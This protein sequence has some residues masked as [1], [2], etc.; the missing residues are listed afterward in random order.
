MAEG[1]K[2]VIIER[3]LPERASD[4]PAPRATV[5]PTINQSAWSMPLEKRPRPLTRR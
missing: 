2:L 4:D 3:L 1:A 5:T